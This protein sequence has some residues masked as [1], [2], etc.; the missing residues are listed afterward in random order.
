MAE[1]F[2]PHLGADLGPAAG[3]RICSGRLV[4]PFHGYEFDATGQ[5]VATPFAAPPKTAK[6][7]VFQTQEVL[8]LVFPWWGIEGRAPQWS[9][10][11]DPQDQPG[12]SDLELKTIRFPGHPQETT[13]NSVD[14]GHL[15]YVH[16]Y[17]NVN[18][19]WRMSVNGRCLESRFDFRRTRT[20]A[21]IATMTFDLSAVTRIFGL[22]VGMSL[23]VMLTLVPAGRTIIDRRREARGML[24]PA[25][26]IVHALPGIER[27]GWAAGTGGTRWP[28]PYILAVLAVTVGLGLATPGLKSEFS[29]RDVLP[30]GGTVLADMDTLEAAVGGSSEATNVLTKAEATETRTLLNVRDLTTAFQDETRRPL[31]AAGPIQTSYELLLRDWTTDSGEPGDKYDPELAALSIGIGVDYTIHVIH[32]YREEFARLRNP[33]EAAVRT[34]ATTGS[35]LLGSALTTALGLGVL[36][37]SPLAVAR[38]PA[39]NHVHYLHSRP[40]SVRHRCSLHPGSSNGCQSGSQGGQSSWLSVL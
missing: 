32:R 5:C 30:R 25:H 39:A 15:R 19:I 40:L 26:P 20:I 24:K 31:T 35:A 18:R 27:A 6:L 28:A 8:G 3:G 13:E 37:A 22:G 36:A 12:W 11:D 16:G 23:V 7:R 1:A 9:L 33:E 34:L 38:L 2:C 4:C 21:K 17:D 29:I 10:P 14:L